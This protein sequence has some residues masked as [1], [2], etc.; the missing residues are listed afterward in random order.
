MEIDSDK[1]DGDK[2]F[3]LEDASTTIEEVATPV[4]T[5]SLDSASCQKLLD[6]PALKVSLA[7]TSVKSSCMDQMFLL[8]NMD[9]RRFV[10]KPGNKCDSCAHACKHCG[11]LINSPWKVKGYYENKGGGGG[12]CHSACAGRHLEKHCNEAGHN[13]IKERTLEK[14]AKRIKH[15]EDATAKA[16][17]FQVELG[18]ATVQTKRKRR[19]AQQK[20][21]SKL[22]YQ[23]KCHS[24]M[25]YFFIFSLSCPSFNAF[26]DDAFLQMMNAAAGENDFKPLTID[27]LNFF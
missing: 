19:L 26:R 16:E 2:V 11:M 14:N 24:S 1:V 18:A 21:P 9:A 17:N 3:E 4:A 5:A 15:E 25:A 22:S 13:S 8:G 23:E 10:K 12:S 27:H 7:S 6:F 20:T